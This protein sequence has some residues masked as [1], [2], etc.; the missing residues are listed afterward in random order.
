MRSILRNWTRHLEH[1]QNPGST[2]WSY[3]QHLPAQCFPGNCSQHQ[4]RPCGSHITP[5]PIYWTWGSTSQ[6]LP[7]P[8]NFFRS[9]RH[10]DEMDTP[11]P[12]SSFS[13]T[14][15][16][17]AHGDSHGSG[18]ITGIVG[19]IPSTWASHCL[20]PHVST[21]AVSQCPD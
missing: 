4:M 14:S 19:R 17:T 11:V 5:P 8:A 1:S 18:G 15:T 7:P 10:G 2:S 3:T 21:A 6:Q 13:D 12:I 9:Q 20:L 16:N